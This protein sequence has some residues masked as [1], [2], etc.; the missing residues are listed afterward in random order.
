MYIYVCIWIVVS[1]YLRYIISYHVY[2]MSYHIHLK[3]IDTTH[4]TQMFKMQMLIICFYYRNIIVT[5]Y[6]GIEMLELTKV[7]DVISYIL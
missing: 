3:H 2:I 6:F 4:I 7:T 1:M 5:L